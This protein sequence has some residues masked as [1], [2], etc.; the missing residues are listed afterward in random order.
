MKQIIYLFLNK[1]KQISGG[2]LKNI[3]TKHVYVCA[4]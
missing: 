2:I 1:N 4:L 3:Y